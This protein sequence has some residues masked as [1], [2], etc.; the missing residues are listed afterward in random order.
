M[1][2]MEERRGG[3]TGDATTSGDM[4]GGPGH[5]TTDADD[6]QQ[7]SSGD[8]GSTSSGGSSD[9]TTSGDMGAGPGRGTTDADDT[10]TTS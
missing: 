6:L 4:G 5:G 8:G 7:N 1:A 2:S 9:A 10:A 3:D